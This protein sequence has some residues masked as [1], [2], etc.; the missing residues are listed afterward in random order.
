[1]CVEVKIVS[2][3]NSVL[4]CVSK[5]KVFNQR[6]LYLLCFIVLISVIISVYFSS[7]SVMLRYVVNLP[8]I[9]NA[10]TVKQ[11]KL[12]VVNTGIIL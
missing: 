5:N 9:L 10:L 6:Q 2:S 8:P 12:V 4:L 3:F 1:M 7:L 11:I